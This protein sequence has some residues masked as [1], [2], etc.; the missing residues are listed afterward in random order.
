MD[1]TILAQMEQMRSFDFVQWE[2]DVQVGLSWLA[3][4]MLSGMASGPVV[5]GLVA[6]Q[7]APTSLSFSLSAGRIYQVAAN[8]AVAVG[9]IAQDLTQQCQQGLNSGQSITLTAPSAGQ[10]Q[11][12]LVQGQFQQLDSVRTGDPNS[13]TVPFYNSA[14]P[15]VP[16]P[17]SINTVRRGLFVVQVI[18]G[19]A[20]TT[21]SEVPPTPTPG[22]TPLYM[23]DLAGGQTSIQTSQ[24]LK[25][26][27]SAGTG[28]PANYPV[29]PFLRGHLLSHHG[30]VNGQAPKVQLGNETQGVLPYSQMSPV[31]TLL[32]ANLTLYVNGTTGSDSNTGLTANTAFATLQAAVNSIYHNYDFNGFGV[33]ISVANGTYTTGVTCVGVPPGMTAAIAFVGNHASPGLVTVSTTNANCFSVFSGA[34]IS[35]D[36]FQLTATGSSSPYNT[37]GTC[38]TAGG[39][40][41]VFNA[42]IFGAAGTSHMSTYAGANISSNGNAYTIAGSSPIH[43]LASGGTINTVLSPITLTGTPNFAN[44]FAYANAI[45]YIQVYSAVYTGA[46]TGT[47]YT[48]TMNGVINTNAGGATFLP[49]SAAGVIAAGGQYV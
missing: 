44:S 15:T 48:A 4:D 3:Q 34:S 17:T 22:W 36:G 24:I 31:R 13:G 18:Q 28:V 49:G 9:A 7:S 5:A 46:A 40:S 2:H 16:I 47:R 14:N 19:A 20:A 41:I 11:W 8:D 10:S 29:A 27:P 33:T 12:N 37:V 1:K 38:L 21:G 39:G 32:S 45:G 42:I 26:A 35:V 25:C 6:T 30:G 23:V 43:M